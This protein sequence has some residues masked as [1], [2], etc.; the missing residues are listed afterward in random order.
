MKGKVARMLAYVSAIPLLGYALGSAVQA[1]GP[2][3]CSFSSDCAGTDICCTTK[4]GT[5]PCSPGQPHYCSN[6]QGGWCS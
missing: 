5:Q 2:A 6:T 1:E 3:C 4:E